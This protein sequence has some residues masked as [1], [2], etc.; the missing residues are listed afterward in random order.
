V[1][2][3]MGKL[4]LSPKKYDRNTETLKISHRCF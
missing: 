2:T 3:A 4:S 1:S